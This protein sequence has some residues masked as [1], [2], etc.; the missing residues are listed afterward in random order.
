MAV[1]TV[2]MKWYGLGLQSFCNKLINFTSDTIK[3]ALTTSS[4]VPDQDV[5]EF[6]DDITNEIVATGYTAGG[7]TLVSPTLTYTGAT[8]VLKLS[9]NNVILPLSGIV[10]MRNVILY[11][12]TPG[13]AA[14]NP[15]I[16][17][18]VFLTDGTPADITIVDGN[19][20][21]NWDANGILK[22]TAGA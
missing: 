2:P 4:Y 15:L 5:H 14:T 11:D 3:I 1:F 22:L 17:Y 19:L 20:T 7:V 9:A 6:F 13:S 16:G 18:G 8:N 21:I 12:S 10:V